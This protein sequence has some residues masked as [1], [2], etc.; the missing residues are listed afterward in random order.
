MKVRY[1]QWTIIL[2]VVIP[3]EMLL[4]RWIYGSDRLSRE[5]KLF[6]EL[7]EIEG[8]SPLLKRIVL[9]QGQEKRLHT[10]YFIC[11]LHYAMGLKVPGWDECCN[12]IQLGQYKDSV[13]IHK[14]LGVMLPCSD[15]TT[16]SQSIYQ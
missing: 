12:M 14:N 13:T 1:D 11:H 2:A 4:S 3:H 5:G 7:V 8:K 9:V 6:D 15:R 10:K 16:T